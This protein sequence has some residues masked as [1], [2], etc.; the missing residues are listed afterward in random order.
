MGEQFHKDI[1]QARANGVEIARRMKVEKEMKAK[2]LDTLEVSNLDE[3]KTAI[4]NI[5]TTGE[6]LQTPIVG[7][8][9]FMKLNSDGKPLKIQ[10]WEP[11]DKEEDAYLTLGY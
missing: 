8:H 2:L 10:I 11:E 3:L 9:W 4:D 7:S 5:G 6:T 1:R